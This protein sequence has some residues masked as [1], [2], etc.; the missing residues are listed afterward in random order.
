MEHVTDA[1]LAVG[2]G[3]LLLASSER[4]P[5]LRVWLERHGSLMAAAESEPSATLLAGRGRVALVAAPDPWGDERW[6][7]RHYHRGGSVARYLGDRYLRLG[8]PR[9]FQEFRALEA[10]R[11]RG[12]PAPEPVG[13][14]VHRRGPFYRGDLVTRW[15]PDSVDLA[16][17][18]FDP[19]TPTVPA[20][21]AEGV[22]GVAA[23]RA[24]GRL[25][26][27]LHERGVEHPDLNLKNILLV[28]SDPEPEALILDLDRA[29]LH[30]GG[31][32][33]P[34]RRRMIARFWRS[35]RKWERRTGRSLPASLRAAFEAGYAGHPDGEQ[36]G[37]DRAG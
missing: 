4:G 26:R 1:P 36:A 23:M 30:T 35:A 25:V 37:P 21:A 8:T 19:E 28:P 31:V 6:V 2:P 10:V 17:L 12:I 11:S 33:A 5:A 18:L 14:T 13:A 34:M 24:A 22:E 15:V 7:V 16:T 27:L 29:R 20:A 9:P 32:P 3:T